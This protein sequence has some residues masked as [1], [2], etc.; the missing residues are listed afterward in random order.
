[1]V[2]HETLNVAQSS[3]PLTI[4]LFFSAMSKISDA[5]AILH[6]CFCKYAGTDG[7]KN[8]MSKKEVADMFKAEFPELAVSKCCQHLFFFFKYIN[9]FLRVSLIS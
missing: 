3:K 9:T 2:F 5:I 6:N 7:D 1:M 8:T 4:F